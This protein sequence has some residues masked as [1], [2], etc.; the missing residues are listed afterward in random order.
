MVKLVS[1]FLKAIDPDTL[2]FSKFH[3]WL[4]CKTVAWKGILPVI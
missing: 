4:N 1:H 2:W 3:N